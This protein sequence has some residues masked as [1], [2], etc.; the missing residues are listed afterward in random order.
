MSTLSVSELQAEVDTDLGTVPLQRIIDS[1]ERTIDEF[2]GTA[3]N[4]KVAFDG[5]EKQ[6]RAELWLPVAASSVDSVVEFSGALHSP[7]K[8]TLAA[9]DYEVSNTGWQLRR[10]A[11]GDNPAAT[12]G[13]RAEV[14]FDAIP[15]VARR[16]DVAVQL[17]RLT[18]AHTA[19]GSEKIG[20]YS[21]VSKSVARERSEILSLLD[22]SLVG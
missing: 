2:C 14:Q 12:W 18:I 7:E 22:D 19:L 3:I 20:D 6:P 5:I 1:A 21:S 8:T 4:Y 17:S 11:T 10:L 16:K 13:W 15:D 9:T